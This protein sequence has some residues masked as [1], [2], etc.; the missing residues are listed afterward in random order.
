MIIRIP[1]AYLW[2]KKPNLKKVDGIL[3]KNTWIIVE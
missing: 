3:K 1:D 2:F